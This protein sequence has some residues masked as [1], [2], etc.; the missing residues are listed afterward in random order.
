ME[1]IPGSRSITSYSEEEHLSRVGRLALFLR[2]C[3]AVQYGHGRGI[4]HRDLKPSNI[5]I[6]SAGRPKVIDFGVA[7]MAGS[8]EVEKEVTVARKFVGAMVKP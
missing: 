2:V 8:D 5:L 3:E 1:Y 6:T 7:L 4:I